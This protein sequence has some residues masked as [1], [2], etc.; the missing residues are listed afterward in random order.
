MPVNCQKEWPHSTKQEVD[1]C[2]DDSGQSRLFMKILVSHC[3]LLTVLIIHYICNADYGQTAYFH[4]YTCLLFNRKTWVKVF[5]II[6]EFR[7]NIKRNTVIFT[8][9]LNMFDI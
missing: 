8:V 1:I 6:P 4:T 3:I 7:L 5:R 9:Y 2:K